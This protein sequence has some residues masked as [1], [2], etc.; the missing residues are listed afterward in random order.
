[1]IGAAYIKTANNDKYAADA[2]FISF[3]V[4]TGVT[5]YVAHD[6]RIRLPGWMSDFSDTG[7]DLNTDVVFSIFSKNFPPGTIVL[8]GNESGGSM[9]TVIVK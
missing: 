4:D 5:V 6:N 1:M 3:N 8:G 2:S 7:D 9:Y